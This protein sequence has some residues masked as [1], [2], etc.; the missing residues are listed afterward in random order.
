MAVPAIHQ[1][2]EA[3]GIGCARMTGEGRAQGD[4]A[5]GLFRQGLG[6]LTRIDAA[7]TPADQADRLLMALKQGLQVSIAFFQHALARA[8]IE[9]LTPGVGDIAEMVKKTPQRLGRGV[10]G[11]K[12]REDDDWMTI[13][14]WQATQPGR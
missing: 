7:Q 14:A 5:A 8:E 11:T 1:F 3:P 6:Q 10:V 9:T 13:A 2:E 12:P 4:D